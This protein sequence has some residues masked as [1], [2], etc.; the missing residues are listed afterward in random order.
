MKKIVLGKGYILNKFCID[1]INTLN[2]I[3]RSYDFHVDWVK[4]LN[5]WSNI[6]Y[7]ELIYLFSN[8]RNETEIL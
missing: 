5:L 3:K 7:K 1:S 6:L 4:L 2:K 8:T